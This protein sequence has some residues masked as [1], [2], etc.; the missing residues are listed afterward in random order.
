MEGK[1]ECSICK[2]LT[3]AL[4][5]LFEGKKSSWVCSK[6]YYLAQKVDIEEIKTK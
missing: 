4:Y 1:Y 6:C 2:T 3:A 5:R